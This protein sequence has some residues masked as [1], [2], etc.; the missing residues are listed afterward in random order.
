MDPLK[1]LVLLELQDKMSGALDTVQ[2]KLEGFKGKAGAIGKALGAVG[3]AA[4]GA[5]AL[6]VGM[7]TEMNAGLSEVSTLI[8]GQEARL[9]ELKAAV[10]GLSVEF[11]TPTSGLVGGLYEGI[12]AFGD[13]GRYRQDPRNE[14]EGGEGGSSGSRASHRSH[15]RRHEGLQHCHRGRRTTRC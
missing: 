9:N 14:H 10:Q 6:V 8:P 5:G 12:S 15:V 1:L 11:G 4:T 3:V 7:A 13:S 2:G